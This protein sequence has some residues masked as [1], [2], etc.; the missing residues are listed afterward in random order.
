[1]RQQKP[2]LR[3]ILTL[4]LFFAAFVGIVALAQLLAANEQAVSIVEQFGYIGVVIL[5]VIAGLNAVVPVPAATLTPVFLSAGMVIPLIILCLTI[6]TLI[7][8]FV[9]FFIGRL[10]RDF[11]AEKY[12][13][14][15][16]FFG[17]LSNKRKLIVLP[18]VALYAALVPF[19]NEAI[20]VPLGLSGFRF[21]T[22]FIPLFLGNLLNQTL[23]VYGVNGLSSF[24]A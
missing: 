20:L 17:R 3:T 24:F 11:V 23:L 10:S 15:I 7:A 13:K 19:P 16:E 2:S 8:D 14:V 12:P 22:L 5:A 9:G 18:L 4:L 21:S 1:M 6:G